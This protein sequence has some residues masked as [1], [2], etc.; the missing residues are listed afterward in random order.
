MESVIENE[1]YRIHDDS[2]LILCVKKSQKMKLLLWRMTWECL[3][4]KQHLISKGVQCPS[5][6]PFYDNNQ[7][8]TCH[9]Y[10]LEA[11]TRRSLTNFRFMDIY[12]AKS[13]PCRRFL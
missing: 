11:I 10:F 2:M 8:Y 7:E 13:W 6:C 9:I 12:S 5:T 4:T 1:A 3:P